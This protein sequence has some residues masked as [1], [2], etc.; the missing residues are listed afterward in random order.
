MA[1]IFFNCEI[2]QLNKLENNKNYL[3]FSKA[4]YWTNK[5]WKTTL[6]DI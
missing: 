2:I 3:C 5:A 6:N 1:K 4:Y